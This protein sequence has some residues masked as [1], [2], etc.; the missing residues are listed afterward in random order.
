MS[1]ER[2]DWKGVRM[3]SERRHKRISRLFWGQHGRVLWQ[4]P[5]EQQQRSLAQ[6][7]ACLIAERT[8]EGRVVAIKDPA[9][10]FPSSLLLLLWTEPVQQ[11]LELAL[12]FS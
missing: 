7:R 4:R 9:L 5:M 1:S 12:M 10:H 3:T 8:G 2:R 11:V 6:S